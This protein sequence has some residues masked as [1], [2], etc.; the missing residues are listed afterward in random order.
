MGH[1]RKVYGLPAIE[2]QKLTGFPQNPDN[3]YGFDL[4]W[5]GWGGKAWMLLGLMVRFSF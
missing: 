5:W 2:A 4:P 3:A 1:T